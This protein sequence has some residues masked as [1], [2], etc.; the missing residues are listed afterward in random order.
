MN[1][2][3]CTLAAAE[4]LYDALYQWKHMGAFT[5]TPTSLPFF[6]DFYPKIKA[7]T[8][9]SSGS[10]YKRVTRAIRK[11]ADGYVNIVKKYSPDS[12]ALAEQFNRDTGVPLSAVDLTWSYASFLTATDRR[13]GEMHISWA[14]SRDRSGGTSLPNTCLASSEQGS[15]SPPTT[16][17]S[18]SPP[19]PT[20]VPSSSSSPV[21]VTFNVLKP[22]IYGQNIFLSLS[23]ERANNNNSFSPLSPSSNSS[24]PSKSS[25]ASSSPF[26][27]FYKHHNATAQTSP[28]LLIPLSANTYTTSNPRWY[29]TVPL[30][31]GAEVAYR[32]GLKEGDDGPL[33]LEGGEGKGGGNDDAFREYVVVEARCSSQGTGRVSLYDVWRG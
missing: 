24:S 8:Y 9:K 10:T 15:Y 7:R 13:A 22:T 25:S 32:Y 5:V 19:T 2:Y 14:K 16:T 6:R 11:Y 27:P 31:A 1:R 29:V 28:P 21:A 12:G 4:Q 20:Q 33:Q 18:C 3:L 26:S 23:T 17:T 30:P